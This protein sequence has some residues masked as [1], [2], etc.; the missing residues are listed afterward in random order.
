M[1]R[2]LCKAI[3]CGFPLHQSSACP[4]KRRGLSVVLPP[5][6]CQ[7]GELVCTSSDIR[8]ALQVYP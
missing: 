1:Q 7:G 2:P 8:R 6:T 4:V 5:D 3:G